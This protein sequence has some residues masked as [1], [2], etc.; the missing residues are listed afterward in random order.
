MTTNTDVAPKVIDF[1]SQIG[2][3]AENGKDVTAIPLHKAPGMQIMLVSLDANAELK[4]HSAPG[5][6]SVQVVKGAI[7]FCTDGG[8]Y[9]LTPGKILTLEANV[10]HSV[11]A[12]E[13]SMILVTK[14]VQA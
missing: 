11:N 9:K 5:P 2:S 8:S 12:H 4:K 6:I 7:S 3:M 1:G 13:S 14:N 10:P